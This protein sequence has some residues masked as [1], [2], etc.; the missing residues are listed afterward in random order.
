MAIK[1]KQA[2]VSTADETGLY[3]RGDPLAGR[4]CNLHAVEPFSLSC[5]SQNHHQYWPGTDSRVV[6]PPQ[7]E[8]SAS[9]KPPGEPL[10]KR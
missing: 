2:R 8:E 7:D 10:L 6:Q 4:Y 9:S 3:S 5:L 1:Q